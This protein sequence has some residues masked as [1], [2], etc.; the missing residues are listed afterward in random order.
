MTRSSLQPG[1][2]IGRGNPWWWAIAVFVAGAAGLLASPASAQNA[3]TPEETLALRYAPI[4]MYQEQPEPCSPFGEPY[5][6]LPVESVL[7]SGDVELR[8]QS[9]GRPSSDPV[10]MDG[11]G[12][13]DLTNVDPPTYMDFPGEALRP[14]CDFE[15]WERERTAALGLRPT[16]YARI[17]TQEGVE[18]LALQYWFWYIYNDWN[19]LHEGDWEMIQLT[20]EV[21]SVEKALQTDPVSAT[22]SQHGG[23]ERSPWDDDRLTI[24]DGTHPVVWVS[25]GSHAAYYQSTIWIGWDRTTGVGCDNTEEP[26]IRTPVD[27]ILMPQDIDPDGDFA[28]LLWNGR[29]G[30]RQPWEFNG[31]RGPTG[32]KWNAPV[33][34]IDDA[35]SFSLALPRS[36]TIGPGP[37]SLFCSISEASGYALARLP[38]IGQFLTAV[39]IAAVVAPFILAALA[40]RYV[41]AGATL[42]FRNIHLFLVA[43]VAVFAVASAANW[44]EQALIRWGA[45]S[46]LVRWTEDVSLVQFITG[47]GLGGFQQL[48]LGLI[49]APAVIQVTYDLM[50][51]DRTSWKAGWH[52]AIRRFPTTVG[53]I[54]LTVLVFLVLSSTIILFPLAVYL[55]VRWL[56]VAQA[57]IIDGAGAVNSRRRSAEIVS[58]HWITALGFAMLAVFLTGI[59]G[60]LTA[61]ILLVLTSMSMNTAEIISG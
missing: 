34:W 16:V 9:S 43:S 15:R 28:W 51:R 7:D 4:A 60:P 5:Q 11:P 14:G 6:P 17:A 32:A 2:R 55:G 49:V 41:V 23:A 27:V 36:S 59:T 40:F 21:S 52:T 33:T 30:E 22:Y 13:E 37:T 26:S 58:G 29:W 54:A 8:Q 50:R 44:I 53:A 45:G 1:R 61:M 35:R 3:A 48:S 57:V 46:E 19:N 38:G 10:L 39:I 18:G 20:W 47:V 42:Y 56:F 12:L 24:E 31:P 25:A